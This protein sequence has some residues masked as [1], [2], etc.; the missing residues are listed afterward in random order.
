MEPGVTHDSTRERFVIFIFGPR[1][2]ER[3]SANTGYCLD[4]DSRRA[5]GCKCGTGPVNQDTRMASRL[6][7]V[8]ALL[9]LSPGLAVGNTFV[10]NSTI[11]AVD[12]VP[13]N[14]VCATAGSVCTLRAAIQEAN[15]LSGAH[16]I[17]LPAGTY[18]LTISGRGETNAATGD[19][20][21]N[22]NITINGDSAATTIVDANGLDRVFMAISGGLTL[23]DLTVQNG[24]PGNV[25][26]GGIYISGANLTLVRVVVKS[27]T[28]AGGGGIIVFGPS[29]LTVTDTTISQNVVPGPSGGGGVYLSS[30]TTATMTR[31]TISGNSGAF[32]GG[33][34]VFGSPA[35]PST[36]TVTDTTIAQNVVT[37]VGSG[38]GG[39]IEFNGATTGTMNRVIVSGNSAQSGGG[40]VV[41]GSAGSPATLTLADS[42][43]AQNVSASTGGGVYVVGGSNATATISRTTISGNS[44]NQGGGVTSFGTVNLSNATISG[45]TST[46]SA[47][48]IVKGGPGTAV[49]LV[50]VTIASNSS[51]LSGAVQSISAGLSARNTI[52]A[53]STGAASSNC[54]LTGPLTDLGNNLE[55]PGTTCGFAL[56]SD[57]RA[58]PLLRALAA[59]GGMTETHA[60]GIGSPAIDAGDDVSCA[61]PPVFGMDQRSSS[62]PVG[63]HCDIGA[64]ETAMSPFTDD[65][66]FAG[67]STI[68][69][70]HV[71]ELRS[72]IDDI[73][74][75]FGLSAVIWTDPSLSGVQM[76]T[77]HIQEMRSAL[78][79]AYAAASRT[80]PSFTDP[81]LVAGVTAVRASHIAE[82][83]AAVVA[84]E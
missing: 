15:A 8:A 81:T 13:G 27:C 28:G 34:Y 50:N 41:A 59:N 47:G 44:A 60:L 51:A 22:G 26:G 53:N 7:I 14:G 71:T 69:A 17:T 46:G 79:A 57:R 62:R 64:Y 42:S 3:D 4:H 45:N 78:L 83:R 33:V 48:A 36:L 56:A 49:T 54:S 39:G 55:F 23:N 11:D 25:S 75:L 32:A 63:A 19:L 20:N 9:L 65:P 38:G 12:T 16:L 66:L 2:H 37:N 73:R 40:I 84:L 80:P 5:V 30:G 77:V 67:F 61:A 70:V 74:V 1:Q 24:N 35:S 82:L 6:P 18:T 31:A 76:K 10:V 68:R 21:V 43:I 72:R 52:I 58:D 29:T